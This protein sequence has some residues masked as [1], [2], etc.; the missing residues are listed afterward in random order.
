MPGEFAAV[1]EAY[2]YDGEAGVQV[3]LS[4]FSF[5]KIL[6]KKLVVT[7][8]TVAPQE[9]SAWAKHLYS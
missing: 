2:V 9:V 3:K 1:G 4:S 6:L 5:V 7:T 8:W